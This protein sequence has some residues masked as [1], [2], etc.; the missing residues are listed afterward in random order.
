V[1]TVAVHAFQ[2]LKTKLCAITILSRQCEINSSKR[3]DMFP[4][5]SP[6]ALTGRTNNK[7]NRTA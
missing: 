2:P 6:I 5:V 7:M 1:F 4:V 3:T